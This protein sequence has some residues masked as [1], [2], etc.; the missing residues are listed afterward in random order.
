M[1]VR[2]WSRHRGR[3]KLSGVRLGEEVGE[4]LLMGIRAFA[5]TQLHCSGIRASALTQLHCS[6]RLGFRSHTASALIGLREEVGLLRSDCG[7]AGEAEVEG[8]VGEEGGDGVDEAAGV[9][10]VDVVAV[11]AF[12]D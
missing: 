5:L 4:V 11:D 3:A 12:G 9:A 6:G 1:Y 2:R 10:A 8:A 7:G